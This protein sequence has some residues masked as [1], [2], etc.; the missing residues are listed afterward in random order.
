MFS[1]LLRCGGISVVSICSSLL[2][3]SC[4][5]AKQLGVLPA[6]Y[7]LRTPA[8]WLYLLNDSVVKEGIWMPMSEQCLCTVHLRQVCRQVCHV[9]WGVFARAQEPNHHQDNSCRCNKSH[10][11]HGLGTA[12]QGFVPAR[13]WHLL[14]L[15]SPCLH[16]RRCCW[17][18]HVS[19][20]WGFVV[21]SRL[22]ALSACQA[23]TACM[24][25]AVVEGSTCVVC[26]CRLECAS[27]QGLPLTSLLRACDARGCTVFT[28][29]RCAGSAFW[30]NK[31]GDSASLGVCFCAG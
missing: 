28:G 21:G 6:G 3:L 18:K 12:P 23:V 7:A 2:M 19:R 5:V 14:M 17:R 26:I 20:A 9:S 29:C 31:G 11:H 24:Q 30:H 22:V 10:V 8:G 27:T 4:S 15:C 13:W 25:G 1:A 16:A